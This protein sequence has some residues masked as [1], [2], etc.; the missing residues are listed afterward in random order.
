MNT[1]FTGSEEALRLRAIITMRIPALFR[2]IHLART[3]RDIRRGAASFVNSRRKGRLVRQRY[4]V[5]KLQPDAVCPQN[6][7]DAYITATSDYDGPE[8]IVSLSRPRHP[9]A[10]DTINAIIT[11]FLKD[12]RWQGSTAGEVPP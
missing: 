12:H 7:L 11:K 8:L 10:S 6:A 9:I 4:P 2:G 3:A 1:D 5:H